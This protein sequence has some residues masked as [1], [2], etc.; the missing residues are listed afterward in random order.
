MQD[1]LRRAVSQYNAL[2]YIDGIDTRMECKRI[3]DFTLNCV[4]LDGI[5]LCAYVIMKAQIGDT[6]V[7]NRLNNVHWKIAQIDGQYVFYPWIKEIEDTMLDLNIKKC[8]AYNC[9]EQEDFRC[10]ETCISELQSQDLYASD[11]SLDIL[12]HISRCDE[13]IKELRFLSR[14]LCC[15]F[16]T[17]IG[18]LNDIQNEIELREKEKGVREDALRESVLRFIDEVEEMVRELKNNKFEKFSEIYKSSMIIVEMLCKKRFGN[19]IHLGEL[20]ADTFSEKINE[21]VSESKEWRENRKER[22]K[23]IN[24]YKRS[25]KGGQKKQ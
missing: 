21:L 1:T 10:Y 12:F 17:M 22:G 18:F 4:A 24:D 6:G 23:S 7:I 13:R 3:T 16:K 2:F 11:L 5:Q 15:E 14:I 9:K 19:Q 20:Y 25:L 8:P